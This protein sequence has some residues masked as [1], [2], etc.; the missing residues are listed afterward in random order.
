MD[1]KI[2]MNKK[3][4]RA[5]LG[6]AIA[7]SAASC[8]HDTAASEE[9]LHGYMIANYTIKDQETF[10]KY[11]AA[12]G[13][14]APLYDGKVIIYNESPV[15]LE[16]SPKSV[17][18]VAE[19]PSIAAAKRFYNSREYTAAREFR[20]ASTEGTV[21]LAEG[22]P[23]WAFPDT[24]TQAYGYMMANYTINNEAT[25]R[26]YMNAAGSLA[27]QYNGRVMIYDVNPTVLEGKPKSVIA[28]AEFPSVAETERFYNSSAYTAARAFRVA[29]TEGS[30]LLTGSIP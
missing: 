21:L 16:G 27:Q 29:S 10:N 12:A 11:M 26:Q 25:F 17:I 4:T 20:I 3:I 2:N 5:I 19:F 14:L 9:E 24:A 18:A 22:S 8:S 23:S 13:S 1:S 6:I 15:T 28:V 30:V 7:L